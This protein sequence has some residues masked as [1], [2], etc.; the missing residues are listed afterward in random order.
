MWLFFLLVFSCFAQNPTELFH[1]APPDVDEALRARIH[2][3]FQ[4]HV[5]GKYRQAE[6]LVAEES[7]D[8][9]YNSNKPKYLSFEIRRIDYADDFQ[10]AK[11]LVLCEMFVPIPGFADKPMKVPATTRWKQVHGQWFWYVDMEE[12]SQTPFGKMKP[13]QP[14]VGAKTQL[15][16]PSKLQNAKD[17]LR[18]IQVDKRE[19]HLKSADGASDEIHITN[20]MP[21]VI[22]LS[23]RG[24]APDGVDVKLDPVRIESGAKG[25]LR[26]QVKPGARLPSKVTPMELRVDQT[27][28][29]IP[30]RV[31]CTPR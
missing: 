2:E 7:K 5:D 24:V 16:D 10:T 3:F 19:V 20:S 4:D 25:L 9:F 15:P 30:I 1:K 12:L 6:N 28:Q 8:F 22:S 13:G 11:A 26:F 18:E 29:V 14:T 21:G 23:L 31:F 27:N 17:L